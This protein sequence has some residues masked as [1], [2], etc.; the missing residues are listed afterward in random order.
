MLDFLD[1]LG[2]HR[3]TRIER[4]TREISFDFEDSE[5]DPE[6]GD[7]EELVDSVV[8]ILRLLPG[9]QAVDIRGD[10]APFHKDVVPDQLL[11]LPQI[12][13]LKLSKTSLASFFIHLFEHIDTLDLDLLSHT[14]RDLHY[15]NLKSRWPTVTNVR[16]KN[17]CGSN[18]P[19]WF[20][21]LSTS[22]PRSLSILIDR[23]LE[24]ETLD[25]LLGY[26]KSTLVEFSLQYPPTWG[27]FSLS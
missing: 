4:F 5:Y 6:W 10:V 15:T 17:P 18:Y 1:D 2:D 27:A 12:K 19:V 16:L 7:V 23:V 13:S 25:V 14:M 8:Q 24:V 20:S 3:L 11:R 26:V 21:L 22:S 9:L